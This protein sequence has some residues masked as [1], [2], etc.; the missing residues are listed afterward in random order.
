M[1]SIPEITYEGLK[2]GK[3]ENNLPELYKLKKC[4]E[5]N[6]WRNHQS[7]FD[8]TI[9]T[10][11][12]LKKLLELE[13][14]EGPKRERL[15][16]KLDEKIGSHNRRDL[17]VVASLLHDIAKDEKLK[18]KED[19]TTECP[20]HEVLGSRYVPN[21][22]DKFGLDDSD[23]SF[24]GKIVA[25][26]GEVHDFLGKCISDSKN[27]IGYLEILKDIIKDVYLEILL[28]C[29]ADTLGSDLKKNKPDEFEGRVNL[30]KELIQ[31]I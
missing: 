17:L 28:L 8:H 3:Y 25:H 26:H 19:G 22:K 23:I 5:N 9:E 12:E 18:I 24:V 29:F 11:K 31:S 4:V 20:S 30:Y 1:L 15:N 6:A 21:F 16:K 13:F 27:K 2:S 10:F 7:V 14:L